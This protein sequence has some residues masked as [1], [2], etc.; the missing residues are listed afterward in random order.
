MVRTLA[1]AK[2]DLERC[3]RSGEQVFAQCTSEEVEPGLVFGGGVSTAYIFLTNARLAYMSAN[4]D[5]MLAVRWKYMS[6]M[7]F[8][9]KRFRPTMTFSFEMPGFSGPI[10]YPARYI[11]KDIVTVAK[12]IL[13][14]GTP[15]LDVPDES[16]VALKVFRPHDNS[17]IGQLAQIMGS[18]QYVLKCS[19][20]GMRAGFC[21]HDGDELSSECEGCLR[22]FSHVETR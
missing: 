18:P 9:K 1:Q 14:G 20:C 22:S 7:E 5:G 12:S 4:N 8:G 13:S 3:M 19:V 2:L 21:G 10:D 6:A 11:T 15:V 16:V 17:N